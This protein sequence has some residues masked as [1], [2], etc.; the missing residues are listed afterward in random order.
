MWLG[1]QVAVAVVE[2]RDYSFNTTPTWEPPYT[3]GAAIK[4]KKKRRRKFLKKRKE[5]LNQEDSDP[6]HLGRILTILFSL[7]ALRDQ[8][9]FIF[10]EGFL[11]PPTD[12]PKKK[13]KVFLKSILPNENFITS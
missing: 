10:G 5:N 7:L 12:K 6:R 3:S 11:F 1:S 9:E 4:S 8:A 13:K 2:A